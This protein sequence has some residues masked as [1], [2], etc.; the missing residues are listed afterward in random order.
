MAS[1]L[2]R[3]AGRHYFSGEPITLR[4]AD[5]RITAVE[6]GQAAAEAGWWL[7]PGLFDV[8]VNGFGGVDFQAEGLA[9]AVL[10]QAVA[11]LRRFGCTRF[12]LTLITDEWDALMARLE[13][14][15]L[16]REAS[17][18]L[19]TAIAGWHVEGPFLSAEPGYHGA[20][21]PSLMRDPS[22]ELIREL[23]AVA[24][25]SP[26]LM[27]LAPERQGA[28]EAI[29]LAHSLGITISL[30]HTNASGE[31]LAAAVR[32][33]ATGFT[34]LGNACPQSL[35]RHDNILWR[36]LDTPG[37]QVSLIPDG[38]HVSPSLFRLIHRTMTEGTV[39]YT[40]DAMA[41]AGAPPGRYS[42]GRLQLEV[43]ADRIVR[44]PGRTNFAGSALTPIEGVFR[45]AA[46]LGVPWQET[47]RR[48]S[49][50]PADWIGVPAGLRPGAPANFCLVR[51]RAD[52]PAVELRVFAAGQEV[53][54]SVVDLRGVQLGQAARGA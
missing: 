28:I 31:T 35:D 3:A 18:T 22:P 24:G 25:E 17:P 10:E 4:W 46:M 9:V 7:A 48:F 11:A 34:H 30:G 21:D 54:E 39:C 29:A 45:A 52:A 36:A 13:R 51:P 38:R 26:L 37:L 43:G 1:D 40:A 19:K 27:T 53:A 41:A 33:G 5:G 20:H 42:L 6:A 44:Q 16:L 32:A 23:R 12:L 50:L 49:E 2:Q 15:K 14:L 47:W 8:Q